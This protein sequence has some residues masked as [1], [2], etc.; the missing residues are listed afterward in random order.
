MTIILMKLGNNLEIVHSKM[1]I[2][3]T[4]THPETIQDVA[5]FIFSIATDLEN[6]LLTNGSSAMN[7]CSQNESSNSW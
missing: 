2:C 1:K 6:N 4:I 5:E 3:L 7:G